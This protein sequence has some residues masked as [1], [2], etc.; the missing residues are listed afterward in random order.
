MNENDLD[1]G[2]T[3]HYF[4]VPGHPHRYIMSQLLPYYGTQFCDRFG[5]AWSQEAVFEGH[6]TSMNYFKA[7]RRAFL[8]IAMTGATTD[9]AERRILA[10]F[11]DRARWT[12]SAKDWEQAVVNITA[13][14]LDL[15]DHS[16]IESNNP[17]S[18]NKKV[19]SLRVGFRWLW[20]SSFIPS[21]IEPEGRVEARNSAPSKCLA[22]VSAEAGRLNV[23]GMDLNE[24]AQAFTEHNRILLKEIRK[25]LWR[26]LEQNL[27]MFRSGQALMSQEGL[28][29][30]RKVDEIFCQQSRRAAPQLGIGLT[31]TQLLGQSL[32]L[33]A[34][35]A[36]G[37]EFSCGYDKI[38]RFV[39]PH[40]NSIDAQPYIEATSNA[41][42]A[43]LHLV[44]ID[45]ACANVQPIEDLPYDLFVGRP[46]GGKQQ[47]R[48]V[49]NRGRT[50]K[51]GNVRH[52]L[53]LTTKSKDDIPSGVEIVEIWRTLTKSM[54]LQTGPTSVRLWLWRKAGEAKVRT[55]RIAADD[56]WQA[57]LARHANNP[58]F[59]GLPITRQHL[60][61]TMANLK[62]A[63][64]AFDL[65]MLKALMGHSL[66][67]TTFEYMSEA[68][69]RAV[70]NNQILDFVTYWEAAATTGVDDAARY[71]GI[72][73]ENLFRRR[74]LGLG[75]GLAFAAQ[76]DAAQSRDAQ[77][78]DKSLPL[79][80]KGAKLFSVNP[81]TLIN[82]ELARR[83]LK[84]QMER[85]IFTNPLR[86]IRQWVSWVAI[87]E[88]YHLILESGGY[89]VMLKKVK[90]K[91]DRDL[92]SGVLHLPLLW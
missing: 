64:G 86:F 82:F 22:T 9:G 77:T 63:D 83:A 24:A 90:D 52:L 2:V 72:S 8:L 15:E 59:G 16:F 50:T 17:D 87:M 91:V 89:R 37:G 80:I 60:R 47:I 68:G 43:A 57:F 38:A 33:L 26:E 46:Q 41:L 29:S 70:L 53:F 35:R 32:R 76:A 27:E 74:Q 10:G 3:T 18:R 31:E 85:M 23:A 54:R 81:Q 12:P 78:A 66:D 20:P 28:L 67:E 56:R 71:L 49:K 14:I 36:S 55:V 6:Q 51:R 25:C 84:V 92:Q 42:N 79:L 11:R 61:T 88:G 39:T 30:T 5:S 4:S 58:V 44:L 69:V 40:I 48:A 19:E 13:R 34:H 65:R 21:G 1:G 62:G 75:N 73:E 7:V 45:A